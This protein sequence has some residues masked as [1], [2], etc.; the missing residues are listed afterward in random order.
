[1]PEFVDPVFPRTGILGKCLSRWLQLDCQAY[2]SLVLLCLAAFAGP[3]VTTTHIRTGQIFGS[4]LP[5][6]RLFQWVLCTQPRLWL[7]VK[8][9]LGL[10]WKFHLLKA[11]DFQR[12]CSFC[13][14]REFCNALVGMVPLKSFLWIATILECKIQWCGKWL[15]HPQ[16]TLNVFP[17]FTLDYLESLRRHRVEWKVSS[18]GN[19]NNCV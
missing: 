14:W 4:H 19:P 2:I 9:G 18:L 8:S 5:T 13:V 6:W 15:P 7:R 11:Q 16:G 3:L 1:M 12:V 10:M 17:E